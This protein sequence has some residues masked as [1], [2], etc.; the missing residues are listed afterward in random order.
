MR[1][2][3]SS[4]LMNI[5]RLFLAPPE[6]IL[7]SRGPGRSMSSQWGILA[8]ISFEINLMSFEVCFSSCRARC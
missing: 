2:R 8:G 1:R 6:M 7:G 4:E 3:N 5:P